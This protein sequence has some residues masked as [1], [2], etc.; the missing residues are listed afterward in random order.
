[1]TMF[2]ILELIILF[3][4]VGNILFTLFRYK[5]VKREL[6]FLK[7]IYY[8]TNYSSCSKIPST[9]SIPSCSTVLPNLKTGKSIDNEIGDIAEDLYGDIKFDLY[10]NS[11]GNVPRIAEVLQNV[12][13]MGWDKGYNDGYRDAKY[14][15]TNVKPA[16]ENEVKHDKE[17]N[18]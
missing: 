8:K 3:A 18:L 16:M 9:S 7:E 2:K 6:D 4:M 1:M 5:R 12:C 17:N 13:V 14:E 15:F 10:K 11:I